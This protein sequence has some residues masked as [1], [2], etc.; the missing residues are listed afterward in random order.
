MVSWLR[1]RRVY[2]VGQSSWGPTL[3]GF[4]GE[5]MR[6]REELLSDFREWFKLGEHEAFWTKASQA[7]STVEVLG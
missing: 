6:N 5:N 4:C 7:G 1:S 3:Y 2:G